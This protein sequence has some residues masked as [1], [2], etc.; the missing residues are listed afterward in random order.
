MHPEHELVDQGRELFEALPSPHAR[1]ISDELV[2]ARTP[3][4]DLIRGYAREHDDVQRQVGDLAAGVRGLLEALP[5]PHARQIAADLSR[6]DSAVAV[7]F[8]DRLRT[9]ETSQSGV[10]DVVGVT[11]DLLMELP[12][13][14]E[15]ASDLARSRT[16]DSAA[17]VHLDHA[18]AR[19]S[20]CTPLYDRDH[21]YTADSDGSVANGQMYVTEAPFLE[22]HRQALSAEEVTAVIRGESQV[23]S[24]LVQ[25][26]ANRQW[27]YT[28]G[29]SADIQGRDI[30][31]TASV[32][33]VK[34]GQQLLERLSDDEAAKVLTM[35]LESDSVL[36]A[37]MRSRMSRIE[38]GVLF[39]PSERPSGA[40]DELVREGE[41]ILKEIPDAMAVNMLAAMR[42][43]DAHIDKQLRTSTGGSASAKELLCE[44]AAESRPLVAGLSDRVATDLLKAT[45]EGENA[46]SAGLRQQLYEMIS[47]RPDNSDMTFAR[48]G[49]NTAN[50][51]SEWSG[52]SRRWWRRPVDDSY[53]SV[54]SQ[55]A[56]M[57]HHMKDEL[58]LSRASTSKAQTLFLNSMN[59]TAQ[60]FGVRVRPQQ[61]DPEK[62]KRQNQL[63][64]SL[65]AVTFFLTLQSSVRTARIEHEDN[66]RKE[67]EAERKRQLEALQ[68]L[69]NRAANVVR[70]VVF[71][72]TKARLQ[73]EKE[74]RAGK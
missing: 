54:L 27:P 22:T 42:K 1:A 33:L 74:W 51:W 72:S 40:L 46:I 21:L 8:R 2:R 6:Q 4:S 43:S 20:S 69:E 66:L 44:L 58:L 31:H 32:Q 35:M 10:S 47:S 15:L 16:P 28:P 61:K 34:E 24:Y 68:E 11:R 55:N 45:M 65:R 71:A 63:G 3:L 59:D 70:R 26:I 17:S 41:A 30:L 67:A 29:S 62:T 64:T 36:A 37:A 13:A 39:R 73:T 53:D 9:L 7:A 12:H 5:S 18:Q 52:A 50:A 49:A 14:R 38:H 60:W 56:T 19:A 23:A 57:V 48:V 25:R